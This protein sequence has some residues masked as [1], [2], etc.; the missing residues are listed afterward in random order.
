[1]AMN[2]INKVF[3]K[4]GFNFTSH[5][6]FSPVLSGENMT[7]NNYSVED[8]KNFHLQLFHLGN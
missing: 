8:N 1:M 5:F 6:C 4:F 2:N 7:Y 3:N